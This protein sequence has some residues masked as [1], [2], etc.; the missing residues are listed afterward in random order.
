MPV[1]KPVIS[2]PKIQLHLYPPVAANTSSP[3]IPPLPPRLVVVNP[4]LDYCCILQHRMRG[5]RQLP[6]VRGASSRVEKGV[7]HRG[8]GF[9]RSSPCTTVAALA[10]GTV[11]Q[12][13]NTNKIP[14]PA[15][16]PTSKDP[17]TL[18]AATFLSTPTSPSR[19]GEPA[20]QQRPTTTVWAT[21]E[22]Y[23]R[24]ESDTD[25]EDASRADAERLGQDDDDRVWSSEEEVD[26]DVVL[27][28]NA[29]P[30]PSRQSQS[31]MPHPAADVRQK[32]PLPPTKQ[33]RPHLTTT[34]GRNGTTTL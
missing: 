23:H 31:T 6:K 27:R 11:A 26:I 24:T 21:I 7:C 18:V 16:L 9:G 5:V 34:A 25:S 10:P 8:G 2:P 1:A 32:L 14:W 13:M 12:V 22:S 3:T 30:V 17:P 19:G 15:W 28:R 20:V 29:T 33:H 4:P